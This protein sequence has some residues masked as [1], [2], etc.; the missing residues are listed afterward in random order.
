[1]RQFKKEVP[2]PGTDDLLL[3]IA[4]EEN[5]GSCIEFIIWSHP[6]IELNRADCYNQPLLDLALTKDK[7]ESLISLLR[8]GVIPTLMFER[9]HSDPGI[10][11]I[12]QRYQLF[13]QTLMLMAPPNT[14]TPNPIPDVKRFEGLLLYRALE[15]GCKDITP[16]INAQSASAFVKGRWTL[17]LA[18]HKDYPTEVISRFIPL[19]SES[20]KKLKEIEGMTPLRAAV[21]RDNLQTTQLLIEN[22][23]TDG[24]KAKPLKD[25]AQNKE[26]K[27]LVKNLK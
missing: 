15:E 5:A 6:E 2:F 26:I 21:I 7:E 19:I 22:G 4:I 13:Q 9:K 16:L 17:I 20:N 12:Q 3:E 1:M 8:N 10:A 14:L 25:L 24:G 27:K 23:F 18:I 11:L